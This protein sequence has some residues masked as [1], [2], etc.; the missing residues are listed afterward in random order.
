MSRS[1]VSASNIHAFDIII[2]IYIY[3]YI[4]MKYQMLEKTTNVLQLQ[5][6]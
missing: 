1:L 4:Y 5:V 3:I 2:Y 6:S